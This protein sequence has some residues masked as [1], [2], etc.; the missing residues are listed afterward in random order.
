MRYDEKIKDDIKK[1][2]N[3]FSGLYIKSTINFYSTLFSIIKNTQM[4]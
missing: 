4:L 2:K 1:K 3:F